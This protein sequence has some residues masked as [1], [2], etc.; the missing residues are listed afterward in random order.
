LKSIVIPRSV[1]ILCKSCFSDC[2]SIERVIF[3]SESKLRSIAASAFS[4]CSSLQ[5]LTL[6][7]SV[8]SLGS[9]CFHDCRSL[10]QLSIEPDSQLTHIECDAFIDCSWL[11]S[12][13]I[14]SDGH[15]NS[16]LL[17]HLMSGIGTP[18]DSSSR[19]SGR[20]RSPTKP[21]T[22]LPECTHFPGK[23]KI[24]L[25]SSPGQSFPCALFS[26]SDCECLEDDFETGYEEFLS[27]LDS[28]FPWIFTLNMNARLTIFQMLG[29][30]LGCITSA[31]SMHA[32]HC[33]GTTGSWW[34]SFASKS[35]NQGLV[36]KGLRNSHQIRQ[37][38]RNVQDDQMIFTLSPIPGDAIP[39]LGESLVWKPI[40]LQSFS[41][42]HLFTSLRLQRQSG[43]LGDIYGNLNLCLFLLSM[44]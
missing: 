32:A 25:P 39:S 30:H 28:S 40:T 6:P 11:R 31:V 20:I 18:V 34:E 4:R 12:F 27:M 10:K 38:A 23:S 26:G 29:Q 24:P 3:E 5:S 41:E 42:T 13:K 22:Q 44:G 35:R 9:K 2:C 7:G 36:Y 15:V 17:N 14:P 43:C 1:E 37:D 16:E 8:E 19:W 33:D 21:V